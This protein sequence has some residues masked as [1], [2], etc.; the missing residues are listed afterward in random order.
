MK[1]AI[2]I[3]ASSGIGKECAKL[4]SK[5]NYILGLAARRVPL[6]EK[7]QTELPNKSYI[8]SIDISKTQE[9]V[10]RLHE[11][12]QEINDVDL[13]I[14]CSGTGHLNPELDLDKEIDT[15]DVN[16]TGFTAM[17]N[18]SVHYYI[19]RGK[20]H[21]V[22]ISSIGAVR[23]NRTAPAYNASKAFISNYM[24]GIRCKMKKENRDI[25]IT[26]IRPGFVDTDMAKGDG[27]FWIISA[28]TAAEKIYEAIKNKKAKAV[29]PGKWNIITLML[30]IMPDCLYC[31]L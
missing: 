18:A 5:N 1:K 3:G 27:L 6:L 13:V 24:E 9:A 10:Q 8:K 28:E 31:R 25:T 7:L 29:I 23:G 4:L 16:V 21:I 11:L 17:M 26:D 2:I 14:I 19:K 12:F 22:G 30:K 20:G 15:I